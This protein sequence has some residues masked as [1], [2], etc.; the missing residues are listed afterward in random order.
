VP[1]GNDL[2]LDMYSGFGIFDIVRQKWS[3]F[4]R[5]D[6]FDDPNPDGA[7][8]AYL[9]IDP[10]AKYTFSLIGVEYFLLPSVRFSPNVETV[11]YGNLRDGTSIKT[12]LVW[13]ATMYWVW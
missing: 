10:R 11:A 6:R 9:P 8:I 3:V 7:G 4:G 5:V 13:R 12:D 1:D 2:E